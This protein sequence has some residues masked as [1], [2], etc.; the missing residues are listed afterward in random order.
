MLRNQE[1]LGRGGGD[2]THDP[3]VFDRVRSIPEI[4]SGGGRRALET[5][6]FESESQ[7]IS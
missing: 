6:G 7:L 2:R 4:F 3:S 5:F 1:E